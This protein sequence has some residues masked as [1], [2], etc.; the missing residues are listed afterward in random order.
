M[1]GEAAALD[2]L[3]GAAVALAASILLLEDGR[4]NREQTT[5][6]RMVPWLQKI[7]FL[8][9]MLLIDT[10]TRAPGRKGARIT[11]TNACAHCAV[12][13]DWLVPVL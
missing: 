4:W 6:I 2:L 5:P 12:E 8:S 10:K 7:T 3:G 13:E 1:E 11:T 9:S